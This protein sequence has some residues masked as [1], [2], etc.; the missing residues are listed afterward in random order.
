MAAAYK[1]VTPEGESPTGVQVASGKWVTVPSGGEMVVDLTED[2]AKTLTRWLGA[3]LVVKLGGAAAKA[4][5]AKV[6]SKPKG[7]A[8]EDPNDDSGRAEG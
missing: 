5:K 4:A 2:Q 8:E 6:P 1:I 3:D 7:E